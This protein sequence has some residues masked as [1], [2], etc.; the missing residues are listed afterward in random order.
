MLP[1]AM[2]RP[3]ITAGLLLGVM[4]V[5]DTLSYG[6]RTAG[7]LA[8]RLAISLS[9]FN[10]LMII[11]RMSNMAQAP[12][13]GNFPDKVNRGAYTTADVVIA[14]R[15]DL[16]FIVAGVIVGALMTRTFIAIT[17][18]GIQLMEQKRGSMWPTVLH[19]ALR[20]WR[21]PY[22]MRVPF[23]PRLR[24]YVDIR[25]VPFGFLIFN[26]LV[27]CFYSIGVMST[28][29]AASWNH[30]LAGTVLMLSGIVNGIATIL[31][32]TIVDPPAAV[33]IDQCIIGKRPPADAKT[34][35]LYLV[36]TRLAGCFLAI[37]LLPLM[38]RY[39]LLAAFWVDGYFAVSGGLVQ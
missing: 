33:V 5:I 26:V 19:G 29:L 20:M 28:V 24:T 30:S 9:L 36:L 35:N 17:K 21:L 32:F 15:I 38:A 18:R 31:L 1:D 11:S 39:V 6:V 3:V 12:I 13:L 34:M 37:L 23:P 16:L 25:T 22:Y 2:L 10:A 14:L 7:V 8:K 4:S 27:T